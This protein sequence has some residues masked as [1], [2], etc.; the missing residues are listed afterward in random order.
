MLSLLKGCAKR[1]K[2]ICSKVHHHMKQ[3]IHERQDAIA[4][5]IT[6]LN[7]DLLT[8]LLSVK[9]EDVEITEGHIISTLI[10]R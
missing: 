7:M 8:A 9:D 10:V 2:A 5:N 6:P 4:Q 1:T 3:I